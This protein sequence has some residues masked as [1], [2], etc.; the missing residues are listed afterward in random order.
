MVIIEVMK[1]CPRI[2]ALLGAHKWS[3]FLKHPDADQV[4]KESRVYY[5]RYSSGREVQKYG[6]KRLDVW[7][8]WFDNFDPIN[9]LAV[10]LC[11]RH[12]YSPSFL[13]TCRYQ[14][15]RL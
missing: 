11:I 7:D 6:W 10:Q 14:P 5:C 2:H 4:D 8:D 1:T 3:L 15:V 13:M 12:H 9:G